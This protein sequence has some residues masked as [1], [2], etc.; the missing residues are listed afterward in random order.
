ME[1]NMIH[2]LAFLSFVAV[3]LASC[4][5]N[6]VS[7]EL[8]ASTG[9][10]VMGSTQQPV[11]KPLN[12]EYLPEASDSN[13]TRGNVS[14]DSSDLL[15]MESYPVQISLVLQGSLPTPCNQLRVIA[16]PPDEQ[17]R[18]QVEAYSVIDPTQVCVQVLEPLDA[19]ISLGSFPTG[20]YSVWVN[21]K[22]I[23]EFEV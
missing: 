22:M 12:E 3:F 21:G 13:L 15:R 19:I 14:I 18:I 10:P 17:N 1:T 9:A 4:G 6:P 2:K 8:P 16:N 5:G 20:H 7:T 23:G 11:P